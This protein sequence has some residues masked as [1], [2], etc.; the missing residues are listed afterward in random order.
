[1]SITEQ[2]RLSLSHADTFQKYSV[3]EAIFKKMR[4]EEPVAWCPEPWEGPGFWS[5]TKYDDIQSVSKRPEYFS[6]D[7]KLGGVTLPS[8][9]MIRTKRRAEGRK[10]EETPEELQQPH[11]LLCRIRRLW[12]LV[13][14]HKC[15]RRSTRRPLRSNCIPVWL[16]TN[17]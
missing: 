13:T 10:L 2:E 17:S 12:P 4:A 11:L 5:V 6:S 16:D 3:P 1:M 7:Q 8:N 15:C 9:E 14:L